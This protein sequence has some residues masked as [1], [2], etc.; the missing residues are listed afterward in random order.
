RLA[1]AA[2]VLATLLAVSPL[3]AGAQAT[4]PTIE[5]EAACTAGVLRVVGSGF[6]PGLSYT[7]LAEPD[8]SDESDEVGS[9]TASSSGEWEL[10]IPLSTFDARACVEH[11]IYW[12]SVVAALDAPELVRL[13]VTFGAPA[14]AVAGFGVAR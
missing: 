13:E 8:L 12:F 5:V 11:L 9:A 7:V 1:R 2:L 10:E 14:P 3:T 6:E 4:T